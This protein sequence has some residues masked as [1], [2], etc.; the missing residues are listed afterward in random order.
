MYIQTHFLL[1]NNNTDNPS[2][3]PT[4]LEQ[5]S[6]TKYLAVFEEQDIDLQVFLS[7]TDNDLK[8]I[9]IE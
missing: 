8:E 2:D 7:L 3:L 1:Q 4:L 5:L 9:G 6:L